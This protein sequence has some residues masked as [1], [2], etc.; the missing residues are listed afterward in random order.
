MSSAVE[1]FIDC[2][3]NGIEAQLRVATSLWSNLLRS[4]PA[5][6]RRPSQV[7]HSGRVAVARRV[8]RHGFDQRLSDALERGRCG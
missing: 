2:W 8:A 7:A 5:M 4:S 3:R 6:Y 1:E